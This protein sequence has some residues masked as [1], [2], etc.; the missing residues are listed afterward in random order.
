M[1]LNEP[2]A[3]TLMTRFL[4]HLDLL[5]GLSVDAGASNAV[6]VETQNAHAD[7]V[8]RNLLSVAKFLGE[9]DDIKWMGSKKRMDAVKK[10]DLR[11]FDAGRKAGAKEESEQHEPN[12]SAAPSAFVV[13]LDKV[14]KIGRKCRHV[15]PISTCLKLYAA[16]LVSCDSI[17]SDRTA[18]ASFEAVFVAMLKLVDH[19]Q[20]FSISRGQVRS[21]EWRSTLELASALLV[22]LKT[23]LGE[24]RHAVLNLSLVRSMS[25]ARI[26]RREEKRRLVLMDPDKA[27]QT[28]AR[29]NQRKYR[30]RKKSS[31]RQEFSK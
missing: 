28:K 6:S 19:V 18:A 9:R 21:R 16:V 17:L 10:G 1:Q 3:I 8:L 2:L 11:D 5:D 29:D 12:S 15:L 20:T 4:N 22:R 31:S 27:A 7:A 24:D 14:C 30:H 26:A 25:A 13:L 23:V